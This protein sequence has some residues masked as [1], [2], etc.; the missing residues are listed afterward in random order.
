M[1]KSDLVAHIAT[2]S[3]LP[4]AAT[5]KAVDAVF[6]AITAALAKGEEVAFKGFGV[7]SVVDRAAREGRNPRTGEPVPIPA[8]KAPKFTAAKAL[9]GAV[10]G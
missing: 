10:Q 9:K 1:I 5:A 2:I 8:S 4:K 6:D 3:N 7:F